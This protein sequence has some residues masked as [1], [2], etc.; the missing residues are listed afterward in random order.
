MGCVILVFDESISPATTYLE[1]HVCVRTRS[2]VDCDKFRTGGGD[3]GSRRRR[4]LL[5]SNGRSAETGANRPVLTERCSAHAADVRDMRSG[6][7]GTAAPPADR[8]S[9]YAQATTSPTLSVCRNA[10]WLR[11]MLPFF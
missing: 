9:K 11:L 6:I 7:R 4:W 3:N 5:A 1:R 2:G 10:V 8:T